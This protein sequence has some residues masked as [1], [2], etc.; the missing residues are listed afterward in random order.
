MLSARLSV[1]GLGG[2]GG[3][4]VGGLRIVAIGLE[5][6]LLLRQIR[7]EH[8]VVVEEVL[9]VMQLDHVRAVGEDLLVAHAFHDRLLPDCLR[10]V[11]ISVCGSA[12]T[13][14]RYALFTGA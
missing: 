5:Q 6:H 10:L 3:V 4:A 14:S 9:Q 11:R 2:F 13:F 1:Y 12:S 7:D 8:P